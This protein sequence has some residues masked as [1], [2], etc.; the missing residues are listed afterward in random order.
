MMN[1]KE[2]YEYFLKEIDGA[3]LDIFK[4]HSIEKL[5]DENFKLAVKL[6]VD[7]L[8]LADQATKIL[9]K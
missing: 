3:N 4:G 2:R 7:R 5:N 6:V 1:E 9:N 8:R